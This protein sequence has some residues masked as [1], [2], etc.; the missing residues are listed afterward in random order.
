MS[1]EPGTPGSRPARGL[2]GLV[3][4]LAIFLVILVVPAPES[5]P[6]EAWRTAAVIALMATWWITEAI[7]IYM[8]GLLPLVL[9]PLLGIADIQSAAAPYG[10][11]VIF[12]FLGGSM[13][14]LAIQRWKLHQRAGLALLGRV[15]TGAR[16]QVGGMLAATAILSMWVSNT[17]ASM[18]M[19]PMAIAV[20][21]LLRE[22]DN[23]GLDHSSLNTALVL[24]VAYGAT[25]GGLSTIIGTPPNAFLVA[26][27]KQTYDVTIGFAEWMVFGVPLAAVLLGLAWIVLTRVAYRLPAAEIPGAAAMIA[28]RR[29]QL[30]PIGRGELVVIVVFVLVVAAWVLT[31]LIRKMA[32]GLDISDAMIAIAGTMLLF[33]LPVDLKRRE[34]ALDWESASKA[35]WGIILLLGGGLSIADAA[36]SSGLAAAVGNWLAVLDQAPYWLLLLAVIAVVVFLTEVASNTATAATLLPVTAALA[37]GLGVD[38]L[39][40]CVPVALAASCGFML[41]A[42]TPPN[43][44]IFSSGHV[45]V[46]QMVRAGITLN[47]ACILVLTLT[48]Y[49]GALAIIGGVAP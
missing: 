32:P 45:T 40:L 31:P 46:P 41:P 25:I 48:A 26:Y 2:R 47:L 4:G 21:A 14:A 37:L 22:C 8:T 39:T 6:I 34:F 44:V 29:A 49:S 12:L 19:L 9:M 36:A 38:P 17:A 3:A 15:G 27:V 1:P 43:A 28:E 7:H 20:I 16:R 24:A 5:M 23:R 18:V 10:N 35:P 42:G 11:P 13:L 33:I 30:G